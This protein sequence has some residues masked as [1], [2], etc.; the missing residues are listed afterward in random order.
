MQGKWID[1]EGPASELVIDGSEIT[2]F[3][4][5][6]AY[7]SKEFV[8]EDGAITVSLLVGDPANEDAFQRANITGLVITAEGDFHAYNLKFASQ[9]VRPEA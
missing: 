8:V 9:Y 6:V 1:A 7:D 3:G 5:A 4:K 2:C